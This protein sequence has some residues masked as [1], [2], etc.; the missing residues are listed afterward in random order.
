MVW[1]P[2]P[3]MDAAALTAQLAV[4]DGLEAQFD[5]QFCGQ[6]TSHTSQSKC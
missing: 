3:G 2:A 6:T 4:Y 1:W 5:P